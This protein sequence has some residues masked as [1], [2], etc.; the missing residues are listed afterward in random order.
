MI[1]SP[2]GWIYIE[3]RDG[4]I[5]K[6]L[7]AFDGTL[8]QVLDLSEHPVEGPVIKQYPNYVRAIYT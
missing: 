1:L 7:V 8:F 5:R 6:D 3:G 2:E 4:L